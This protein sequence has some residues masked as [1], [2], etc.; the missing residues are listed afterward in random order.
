MA[1]RLVPLAILA[2]SAI[3]GSGGVVVGAV[4]GMQIWQ[5]NIQIG[6]HGARY[7]QRYVTHLAEVNRTNRA[8][9]ALGLTQES[10]QRDVIFRMRDFLELH[11]KQVRVNE[12]L[13]LDGV[14]GSNT[15]IVGMARLDP[16]VAKWVRGVVGSLVAGGVTRA[17]LPIAAKKLAKSSTG[18]AIK[19]LRGAAEKSS[20]R[21]F[22]G[23]GS[24]AAGG[25]GEKLG[26]LVLK[27]A[28]AG[29]GLLVA[30]V[31][32]KNEGTKA[33][34]EA[35]KHLTDVDVA[36]AELEKRDQIFRGVRKRAHELDNVLVRL[37][38]RATAALDLLESE[39]FIMDVHG[40]RLQNALILV[41]SVADVVGAPVADENG[42]I[43]KN[44]DALIIKYRD[45]NTEAAH[46]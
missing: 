43:D 18:T 3:S 21:A 25:G 40:K 19:S 8:L 30:G 29:P 31:M 20:V 38:S 33:R 11:D 12:Y 23:G 34:S 45:A 5:A 14:E 28:G 17:A 9:Q 16:D 44:V 6:L 35:D 37:A 32:V 10:G 42:N 24:L 26:G 15:P 41:K 36:I 46:A 39:P 7:E 13:I 27:A 4:G 1:L 22:F 2:G